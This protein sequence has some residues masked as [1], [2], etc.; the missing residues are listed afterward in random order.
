[1]RLLKVPGVGAA[2][3]RAVDWVVTETVYGWASRKFARRHKRAGGRAHRYLLSWH[4][5]D[6]L[7]GAAHTID[8]PLLLG[9]R[10]T[11]DGVGL[12]AGAPWDKVDMTGRLVRALWAGFARGDDLGEAGAVDDALHYRRV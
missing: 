7:F 3:V 8:L 1:M 10:G 11:W 2:A 6:N 5:P 12:I 9:N 4:A